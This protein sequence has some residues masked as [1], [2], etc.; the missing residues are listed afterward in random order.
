MLRST[1]NSIVI[2]PDIKKAATLPAAVY[3]DTAYFG[4]AREQVFARSWQFVGDTDRLKGPGHVVPVTVLEGYLDEP[5]LLTRDSRDQLNCF[6]NVCTHRGNLLVEGE[7]H[8]QQLRCRYHGRCF[9]LDGRFVSAPGFDD[10]LNFPTDADNLAP[11]SFETW[12]KF[13]FT[14]IDPA[15]S[16]DQLISPLRDRLGWLPLDQFVFDPTRS[17]DYMVR[18]N[19][20]LYCDNYLEGF[21]IPYVHPGLATALDVKAYRTEIFDYANLQLGVASQAAE[22][23][24]LPE[25]SPDYGE[26]I[27]AYYFWLFPNTM[28]NFYPWGLSINVVMP[29]A[30][31]RTKVSFL[32]YVWDPT[33]LDQGGDADIDR[34]E[35]E[36]EDI[37]EKVQKG[38]CSRF[39]ERG[40]YS[41]EREQG[42]HH[43]HTLL[44]RFLTL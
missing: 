6:S 19:W 40:R 27:R 42:V 38:V 29:L 4:A 36:D 43:F 37:V 28:F 10:A 22:T 21:H 39:Y 8:S 34:V 14:A 30:P 7:C 31:D 11:V 18:A 9:A 33:E 35:R 44:S 25:S 26:R 12:G 13:I 24:D 1:A 32:T 2:D 5:L 41:P 3:R 20:A 17:R 16:F 15:Y 23:F